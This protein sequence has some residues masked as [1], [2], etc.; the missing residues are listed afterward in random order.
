MCNLINDAF[1][2]A[3]L[4]GTRCDGQ[5]VILTVVSY[6]LTRSLLTTFIACILTDDSVSLNG[7][8]VVALDTRPTELPSSLPSRS[9]F[10]FTTYGMTDLS[11]ISQYV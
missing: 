4:C 8:T 5:F 3:L 7:L 9:F 6:T 2:I 10:I 11:L 1:V